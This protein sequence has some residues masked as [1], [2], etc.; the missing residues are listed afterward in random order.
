VSRDEM[1]AKSNGHNSLR[2]QKGLVVNYGLFAV[3]MGTASFTRMVGM[4]IEI[5]WLIYM[6]IQRTDALDPLDFKCAVRMLCPK[7]YTN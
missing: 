7:L 6:Q 5:A 2:N 3:Q 4:A 1:T